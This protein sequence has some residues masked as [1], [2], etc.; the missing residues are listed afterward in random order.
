[1]SNAITSAE[2]LYGVAAK[3]TDPEIPVLSIADL[4]ILREVNANADGSVQVVITPT[5][6]GCPAM[7]VITEDLYLAFRAVGIEKV[8]VKLVLTPA[9]STDWM[10]EDGKRK[11]EEYGI[12]PPT[13]TGHSGRV[14]VGMSVKCP[15]CHSLNT[16]ELARFAST[17]CKALYSCKDC[18]EPFDYFKVLS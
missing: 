16:R 3:V 18:L 10:T 7:D 14:T 1:M 15:R 13:G 5:Y 17:S 11:L 8:D 6:S 12:A 4:G 9:W 2:E